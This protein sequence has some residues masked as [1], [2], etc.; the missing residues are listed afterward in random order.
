[1]NPPTNLSS[2]K[3]GSESIRIDSYFS[4]STLFI[5]IADESRLL[6]ESVGRVLGARTEWGEE[7]RGAQ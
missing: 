4:E 1:M 5:I 2:Q 6:S 3:Y 7:R